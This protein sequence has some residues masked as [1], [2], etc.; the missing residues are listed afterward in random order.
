MPP[1]SRTEFGT[2]ALSVEDGAVL[3][4]ARGAGV[5]AARVYEH[6]DFSEA[7]FLLYGR[8]EKLCARGLLR[9]ERWSGDPARGSG[10]VEAV[11][12]P[13]SGIA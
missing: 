7:G 13:V 9:F 11:F 12:T 6:G 10:R 3:M 2:E 4:T 5:I 1:H 8:L